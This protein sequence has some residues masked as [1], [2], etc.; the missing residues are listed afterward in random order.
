ML[1]VTLVLWYLFVKPY[2]YK[3]TFTSQQS[4][5]TIYSSLIAWNHW[6]PK[7]KKAVSVISKKPFN[8]IVQEFKVAD[9]VFKIEWLLTRT[10]DSVTKVEALLSDTEHRLAQRLTMPF[11]KTDFARRALLTVNNIRKGILAHEEDYRV[12]EVTEA[13]IPESHVAYIELSCK[14]YEKA[15]IMIKHTIDVMDYIRNNDLELIGD[16]F[17]EIVH[18]DLQQD[19]ITFHFCFPVEELEDYPQ[20]EVVEIKTLASKKAIKT[21]FNGNYKI[22]DRGWYHLIDYAETHGIKVQ[23][24]PVEI[25]LNDPH[26]GGNELEWEAQ[27]FLP[28]EQ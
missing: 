18:W 20:S 11:K 13:V 19:Q 2:D 21:R 6:E 24:L 14:T 7:S 3:I 1:A 8:S 4:P 16:P 15:N 9:S 5:G 12:S 28:L 27:V 10:S 26:S 17:L 22:S 23:K 25:F